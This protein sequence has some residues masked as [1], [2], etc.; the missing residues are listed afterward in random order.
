MHVDGHG[1]RQDYKQAFNW[2]A[3]AAAQNNAKAQ[4]NIAGLYYNGWGVRQSYSLAKEWFGK[5]CDNGG[6]DGCDE[7]RKLN[8]RG[9]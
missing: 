3:K 1:V 2:Y 7:Y 5:A 9:Y 4:Y 6:Q 8:Q